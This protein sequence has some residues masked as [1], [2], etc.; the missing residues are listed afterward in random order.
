MNDAE[1]LITSV[2]GQLDESGHIDSLPTRRTQS[3]ETAAR[4]LLDVPDQY[5]D[6]ADEAVNSERVPPG[7]RAAVKDYFDTME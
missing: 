3:D 7:Y 4:K 5:I 1:G 2:K 6:A